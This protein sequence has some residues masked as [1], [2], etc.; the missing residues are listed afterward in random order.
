[1]P[2]EARRPE[3]RANSAPALVCKL[4][5]HEGCRGWTS[6]KY[7][8]MHMG[9]ALPLP[10]GSLALAPE[11]WPDPRI[12][13]LPKVAPMPTRLCPG[14]GQL[15]SSK[16]MATLAPALYR[17]ACS[18]LWPRPPSGGRNTFQPEAPCGPCLGEKECSGYS[19]LLLGSCMP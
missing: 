7:S 3:E 8:E 6:L 5:H 16:D 17:V 15:T 2:F 10:S 11:P 13:L 18:G 9:H 12:A 1:M 4:H 14:R 19:I